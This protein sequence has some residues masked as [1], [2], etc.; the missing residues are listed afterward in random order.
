MELAHLV[1]RTPDLL[2]ADFSFSQSSLQAYADCPRRFWLT[3]VER[4]PWPAVEASPVQEHELLMR[5]GAQF[6]LLVQR[7][8]IGLDLELLTHQLPAPLDSWFAAYCSARPA[9]LPRTG[10]PGVR[11]EVE[12][13]LTVRFPLSMPENPGA[14]TAVK[15]TAKYD[16]IAA[17]TNGRVII[18]DWKTGRRRPEP[19]LLR[20]RLQTKVYLYVLVEAAPSLG[21]GMVTPEQ[22]EMRYWFT[23]SPHQ[24]M[25]FH[26]DSAQHAA[27]GRDLRRLLLQL[28]VGRTVADFP[29][30]ADTDANRARLCRYCAYRSRCNRGVLPG[31]LDEL[32]DLDDLDDLDETATSSAPL[33]LDF[34]LDDLVEVAF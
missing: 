16:L 2:P 24:P 17:D 3:Y 22:V 20:D 26:Y 13:V 6:H 14:S 10:E 31:R 19:A 12:R 9:D 27:N 4:L 23:A 1:S 29:L 8:E 11:T 7:A 25:T 28:T 30:V 32:D 5:L 21:W 15:L 33:G 34:D 18:V